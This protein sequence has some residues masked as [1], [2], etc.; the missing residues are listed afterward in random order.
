[1]LLGTV[2]FLF[3]LSWVEVEPAWRV[4][5]TKGSPWPLPRALNYYEGGVIIR[6]ADF[7]FKVPSRDKSCRII[8]EAI[9]RYNKIIQTS[10]SAL[11]ASQK[12]YNQSYSNT[13]T[14][15]SYLNTLEIHFSGRCESTPYFGMLEYYRLEINSPHVQNQAILSSRSVWGVL[16]GLETFSQLIVPSD[17]GDSLIIKSISVEDQPRFSHRGLL[18]DT[19]RHYLPV[20]TIK[21]ILDAMEYNK[22][23]VLHWHIVD[24]DSFP[25]QSEVFPDLSEKG[26]FDSRLLIYSITDILNLIDYASLRGIRV[27]PEFDT[28]G[29]TLSWGPGR[30]TLLTKCYNITDEYGPIDPTN[31]NNYYFLKQ[32]FSEVIKVFPD[33]YLHLGGDEVD[34]SCW[35][36]N[37]E[38]NEFMKQH[39]MTGNYETL[40]SYYIQKVIDIVQND[41]KTN[42]LVW[43][44]VFDNKVEIFPE[45]IVHV[46]TGNYEE[47]IYKVTEAGYKTILS[48][49]W[50]LD[51]LSTGG[52]WKKYYLCEPLSF[53][54]TDAQKR[55]VIGGEACMWG[56]VVDETNILQRIW[57]RASAAA[58]KLWSPQPKSINITKIAQRIEEHTCRMRRRGIPAQ[59]PN[60]PAF[61]IL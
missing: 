12:Y 7:S 2:I 23:N 33:K 52:D 41:L 27:L 6:P 49:C 38:I 13:Q 14:S 36:S 59:P 47:E 53:N 29:H 54:G 60:G 42:T 8:N 16:R 22:M 11:K 35:E 15:Y 55:L 5:P 20:D 46:W 9:N 19:S 4:K 61:C 28:P 51:H 26:A 30:P 25:Y 1:M 44:E 45:T 48:T 34:F 56:E 57:P 24:D 17:D 21:S 31:D 18:I 37:P 10:V 50:Y 3:G 43:Q 32:L 40:E 58:E 39:N